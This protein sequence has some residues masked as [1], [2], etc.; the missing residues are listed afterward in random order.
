MAFAGIR[1]LPETL[2][3]RSIVIRRL[4]R[5]KPG[6]VKAHLK[7]GTSPTLQL[8]KAK[9]ARWALDLR[10]FPEPTLPPGLHNRLGDNW[11]P[12]FAIAEI[13]GGRWPAHEA[14]GAVG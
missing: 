7:N 5:A 11:A 8:I 14:S 10:Q 1:E 13:A 3:D 12:L 2:Q 4:V 9:L 6:E